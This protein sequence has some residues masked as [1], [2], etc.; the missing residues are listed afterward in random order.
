[1]KQRAGFTLMELLVVAAVFSVLF[2]VATGV[3]TNAFGK[4][5]IIQAKQRVSTEARS[6]METIARTVRT[7]SIDYTYYQSSCGTSGTEP[8]DLV[9]PQSILAVRDAANQQTCF[10]VS[11]TTSQLE[12]STDCTSWTVMTPDDLAIHD[13]SLWIQ[14]AGN[15]FRGPATVATDCKDQTKFDNTNGVC[16]CAATTDC[17]GGQ[18]CLPISST[19]AVTICKNPNQQPAVTVSF[20]LETLP[21]ANYPS[22]SKLQSTIVTRIYQR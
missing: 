11:P 3:Y 7:G 8:C 14:P 16:T 10:R 21:G 22:Q 20:T 4:Q 1:M 17:W 19:S 13:F 9:L 12:T 6:A 5:K 2:L 15:P 18:Q